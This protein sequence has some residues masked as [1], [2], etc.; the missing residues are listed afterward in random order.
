VVA[1]LTSGPLFPD[2]LA[3][4]TSAGWRPGRRVDPEAAER[5]LVGHGF[6]V[7]EPARQFLSEFSGLFVRADA[8]VAYADFSPD[9]VVK[10]FTSSEIELLNRHFGDRFCPVGYAGVFGVFVGAAGG[11][12]L[13]S[14]TLDHVFQTSAD[15]DLLNRL[16][17]THPGQPGLVSL[18][19]D[20]VPSDW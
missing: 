10:R 5:R 11:R 16:F 19:A 7:H 4:L 1:G 17:S 3:A 9:V 14:E 15:V 8:L 2:A 13:V 6:V 18:P 20:F 12:L